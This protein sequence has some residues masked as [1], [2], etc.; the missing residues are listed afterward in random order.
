M[1]TLRLP[2]PSLR[3]RAPSAPPSFVPGDPAAL[4]VPLDPALAE[5]RSGLASHRRRLWMRRA[6]RRAWYVAAVVAAAELGLA[7]A[8]RLFPLEGAP[9]VAL[10]I[11]VAGLLVWL[12]LVVRA[13]PTLGETALAVDA[14]GGAGDAVASALAFA[15]AMPS[16]AG[17]AVGPDDE[18]IAVDGSFDVLEA[19]SRFVRRQRRD[20]VVRLGRSTSL[21]A[22]RAWSDVPPW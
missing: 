21:F 12:A 5:I 8:Q 9:L 11:P 15:G 10:A 4:G 13:R 18:T 2:R 20:A 6:I 17:P 7:I 19:E 1:P 14:E 16:T 22:A 3:R